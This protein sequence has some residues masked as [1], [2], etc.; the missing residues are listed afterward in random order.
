MIKLPEASSQKDRQTDGQ[1]ASIA[2][3]SYRLK[4]PTSWQLEWQPQGVRH[5]EMTCRTCYIHP[6]I[7]L[8]ICKSR[9]TT[10]TTKKNYYHSGVMFSR[11]SYFSSKNLLPSSSLPRG[12]LNFIQFHTCH[13]FFLASGLEDQNKSLWNTSERQDLQ[14]KARFWPMPH[15][16]DAN[17]QLQSPKSCNTTIRCGS[18]NFEEQRSREE[19]R[20]GG[21]KLDAA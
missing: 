2:T 11:S 5:Y 20:R 13:I 17:T 18:G 14:N 16:E 1:T 15:V 4:K 19:I 9:T 6:S 21:R 3:N 8:F 10:T 12:S 7:H